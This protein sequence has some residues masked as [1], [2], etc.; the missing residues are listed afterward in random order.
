[1][2][3]LPVGW[4]L[5]HDQAGR[6]CR[7]PTPTDHQLLITKREKEYKPHEPIDYERSTAASFSVGGR[8]QNIQFRRSARFP[9]LVIFGCCERQP[10]R[11]FCN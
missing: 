2:R 1:M 11:A 4:V 5:P 6:R 7:D 8:E 3:A 10:V 9:A